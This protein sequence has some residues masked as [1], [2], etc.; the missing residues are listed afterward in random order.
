NVTGDNCKP[1]W[2]GCRRNTECCSKNCERSRP[3]DSFGFCGPSAEDRKFDGPCAPL[4]YKYC[5]TDEVCCTKHC[6]KEPTWSYG[7]CDIKARKNDSSST[8][9]PNIDRIENNCG[10]RGQRF[11]G[12]RIIG[13]II[14]AISINEAS[15]YIEF[16][17]LVIHPSF[18]NETGKYANDIALLHTTKQMNLYP[19]VRNINSICLPN[20]N[21][22]Y[23]GRAEASGWG[24]I[25][26]EGTT[27]S[28]LM[29]VDLTVYDDEVCE[30]QY[31][32]FDGKIMLCAGNLSGGKDSCLGDSGGPLIISK[33]GF[34]Y[35]IGIV[36]FG[37]RDRSCGRENTVAVYTKV[38]HYVDWI[39]RTIK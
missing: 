28:R 39:N 21:E 38:S 8:I 37:P 29:A 4:W 22:E 15:T 7:Y 30:E 12:G 36:S 9:A 25:D 6:T 20:Q 33:S 23:R 32:E 18:S 35:L 19:T 26:N 11:T 3:T 16:D 10:K 34:A 27:A 24:Q 31:D 14:G 13:G 17:R 5:K 2:K 1:L